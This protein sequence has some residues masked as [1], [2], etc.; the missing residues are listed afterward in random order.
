MN[1]AFQQA[2]INLG[3]TKQNPSVGCV[4]VKNGHLIS[5]GH[6]NIDGRPHAEQNAIF[7]SKKNEVK[8]SDIYITLEP[9]SHK[10][11]PGSC[12]S[13]I[14]KNKIKRVFF[15]VNDPDIRSFNK[16]RQKFSKYGIYVKKGIL[17]NKLNY[18][19]K[20]YFNY[21]NKKPPFVTCKIAISKDF[22][23]I[24]KINKL[25]TNTY[26]RK[27]VQL[28]RSYHDCL[29][30]SSKTVIN[31]NPEFTC[32]IEG[33]N[34]K[35]P[36]RI[37]L[38]NKLKINLKSKIIEESKKYRTIIFY[39]KENQIKLKKLRKLRI[40]TFKISLNLDG[41]LNLNE[42]LFKA[43]DLGFSRI[44]IESGLKLTKNF[45]KERLVDDFKIFISDKKLKNK[46]GGNIKNFLNN[47]LKNKQGNIEKV[48]LLG[49]RLI[50]Y[51]LK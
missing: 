17:K 36:S 28:I 5:A 49:D 39:N 40:K 33:L 43:R 32:R 11:K 34:H 26:S 25:I 6:T 27:R 41:D 42:C 48:N 12:V 22:F 35:S 44:F 15:S 29:I 31:D 24:N 16:S 37:I 4:I 2:R 10:R 50:T 18:F 3:N 7:N 46:G 23:T 20:S 21:K 8:N 47:L 14:I 13:E 9:C 38:D 30:S 19:Y 51:K 45:L 1:L